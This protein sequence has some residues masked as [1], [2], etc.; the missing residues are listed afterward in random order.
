M[1]L[2]IFQSNLTVAIDDR[3]SISRRSFPLLQVRNGDR[4]GQ[5]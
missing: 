3:D 1:N 4:H 2:G 5:L